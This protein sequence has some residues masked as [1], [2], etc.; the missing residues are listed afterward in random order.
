MNELKRSLANRFSELSYNPSAISIG[1]DGFVFRLN[2]N[3][4]AKLFTGDQ[5]TACH[6]ACSQFAAAESCY[7]RGMAIPR[8]IALFPSIYPKRIPGMPIALE[9]VLATRIFSYLFINGT[10]VSQ[11]K[12]A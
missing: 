12:R 7:N 4:V 1:S 3:L 10:E 8:P 11:P 5:T 9:N 2:K 6:A